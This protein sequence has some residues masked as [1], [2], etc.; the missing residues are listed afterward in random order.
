MPETADENNEKAKH[1]TNEKTGLSLTE[2]EIKYIHCITK[3][4]Y[5]SGVCPAE[6]YHS[7][8]T[9]WR[10]DEMCPMSHL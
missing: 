1:I 5:C 3:Y 6:D 2:H 7:T 4:T 9:S 10:E 8:H